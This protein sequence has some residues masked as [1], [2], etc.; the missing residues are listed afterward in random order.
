MSEQ[1]QRLPAEVLFQ[2]EIEY[3]NTCIDSNHIIFSGN[4]NSDIYF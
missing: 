4:F 2:K 1:L 3:F